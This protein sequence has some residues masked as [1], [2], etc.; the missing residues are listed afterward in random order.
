MRTEEACWMWAASL[1]R[2][3]EA[4][5]VELPGAWAVK[6]PLPARP[7]LALGLPSPSESGNFAG[8]PE[9]LPLYMRQ[10]LLEDPVTEEEEEPPAPSTPP[11]P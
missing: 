3:A 7:G 6:M 10:S 5:G 11:V 9:K 8:Q 2:T 1:T 4:P